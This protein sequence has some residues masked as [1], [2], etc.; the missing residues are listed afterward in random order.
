MNN[1]YSQTDYQKLIQEIRKTLLDRLEL[2]ESLHLP[3]DWKESEYKEIIF[4]TKEQI[5][6]YREK[7][8]CKNENLNPASVSEKN[9]HTK[10]KSV[11]SNSKM[12]SSKSSIDLVPTPQTSRKID[13]VSQ[14]F[15]AITNAVSKSTGDLKTVLHAKNISKV[16]GKNIS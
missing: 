3:F 2:A 11:I 7:R 1:L 10:S 5:K 14:G 9:I 4:N 16:P 6:I 15:S 13:Q 8:G 12:N